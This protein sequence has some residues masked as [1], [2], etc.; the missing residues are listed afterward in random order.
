MHK[1]VEELVEMENLL[2]VFYIIVIQIDESTIGL[3]VITTIRMEGGKM[4]I[5][6]L[7]IRF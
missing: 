4:K 7:Y 1:N 5:Y 3:F 6:W 2:S